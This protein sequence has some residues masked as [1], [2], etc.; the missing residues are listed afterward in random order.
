MV[1]GQGFLNEVSEFAVDKPQVRK[2]PKEIP[3]CGTIASHPISDPPP[4]QDPERTWPQNM[5][6][7]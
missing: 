1:L 3:G 2:L 5:L 4:R 6:R 7:P